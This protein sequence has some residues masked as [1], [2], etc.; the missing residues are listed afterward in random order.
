MKKRRTFTKE[1]KVSVLRELEN[2]KSI[3][4]V[5]R[6]Q[7]IHPSM[8]SKWRREYRENPGMAFGGNGN[9]SKLNAK[10]AEYERIIGQQCAEINFLK[11][12]L[13]GLETKLTE[14]R[15]CR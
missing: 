10:V 1:F 6:E 13:S 3:A 14:Y 7:G 4:Q 11:K 5:C 12:T 2:D 15:K 8:F 9:V